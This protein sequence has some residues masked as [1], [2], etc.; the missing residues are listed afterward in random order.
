MECLLTF[1][2]YLSGGLGIQSGYEMI[3]EG[4]YRAT[5]NTTNEYGLLV[6]QLSLIAETELF[7]AELKHLSGINT[8]EGD[9]GLNAAMLGVKLDH[10]QFYV[11]TGVGVQ[12]QT[13]EEFQTNDYGSVIIEAS[14]G[15]NFGDGMFLQGSI[16]DDMSFVIL[17]MSSHF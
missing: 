12:I 7:F 2:I 17:G 14:A 3:E 13:S 16:V 10:N 15:V 1:C 6:G 11:K 4:H 9:I 5:R 8:S